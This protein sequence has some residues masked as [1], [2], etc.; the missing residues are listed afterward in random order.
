MKHLQ[1]EPRHHLVNIDA[2]IAEESDESE[3]ETKNLIEVEA[4]SKPQRQAEEITPNEQEEEEDSKTY[5][6]QIKSF[7]KVYWLVVIAGATTLST[8]QCFLI[9]GP[10]YIIDKGYYSAELSHASVHASEVVSLFRIV[11]AA[12]LPFFGFTIDSTG[13]RALWLLVG[14]TTAT[15]TH[16][17]II[18][19]HPIPCCILYGICY[20]IVATSLWPSIYVLIPK[21]YLGVATGI[22]NAADNLGLMIY[23]A[24]NGLIK[25]HTGSYDYS[26][27]FLASITLF[28]CVC[29]YET[30]RIFKKEKIEEKVDGH[31]HHLHNK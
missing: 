19:I 7:P 13:N 22:V 28:A 30:Y 4:S 2:Y 27:I 20:A 9:I 8:I 3:D 26:Q 16:I 10:S 24:V 15:V 5:F 12:T 11:A 23:P 29:G 14:V 18:F 6:Q 17:L 25:N 31:H 1:S 21:K